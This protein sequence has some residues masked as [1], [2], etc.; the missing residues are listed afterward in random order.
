[1]T[2]LSYKKQKW[3]IVQTSLKTLSMVCRLI[4]RGLSGPSQPIQESREMRAT[5]PCSHAGGSFA[6]LLQLFL[7]PGGGGF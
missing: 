1:M 7:R 5:R 6:S 2:A 4:K 3:R